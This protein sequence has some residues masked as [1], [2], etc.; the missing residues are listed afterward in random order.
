M[1]RVGSDIEIHTAM[2]DRTRDRL[3]HFGISVVGPAPRSKATR[4]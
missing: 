4:Q 1:K 3:G 2:L